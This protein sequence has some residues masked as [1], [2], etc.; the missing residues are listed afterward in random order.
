MAELLKQWKMFTKLK[1]ELTIEETMNITLEP[2]EI[3][4]GAMVGVRRRVSSIA[5]KLDRGS[6]QGDPWGIDIEGALAEV[7]VA[8]ALGIYFSGSVDTYKS[9][10]LAGIQVRWTPLDQGRLIVR[11]QDNDNENYILVTGTCPNY[12]I[13]GWI[14]GFNAKDSQYISAPNGRSA[15]YFV[16]QE[17]LKPMRIYTK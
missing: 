6:T 4:M 15:A 10:D 3:I 13:S 12:K 2:Y 14:E 8:K 16:P 1:T 7:A 17:S 9:P 11:D 5:K